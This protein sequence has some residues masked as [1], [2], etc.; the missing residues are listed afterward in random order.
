MLNYTVSFENPDTDSLWTFNVTEGPWVDSEAFA[1]FL[2]D[3]ESIESMV[4]IF[5]EIVGEG[6]VDF[7][8][9]SSQLKFNCEEL[10]ND[11]YEDVIETLRSYL[12]EL[13]ADFTATEKNDTTLLNGIV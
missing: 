12:S 9:S 4:E 7:I 13:G 8:L 6:A 11:D 2:E 3:S 10:A 1:L 5:E